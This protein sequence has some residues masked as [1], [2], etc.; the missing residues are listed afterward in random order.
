MCIENGKM[1]I[2]KIQLDSNST[3]GTARRGS[4][5]ESTTVVSTDEGRRVT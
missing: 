3:P 2:Y 4:D 1:L 5:R